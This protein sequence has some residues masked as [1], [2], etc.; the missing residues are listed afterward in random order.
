MNEEVELYLEDAKDK[1]EKAINHLENEMAKVR[2][3][4]ASPQM[5]DGIMVDNYGAHVPLSQV[6]NI[7]T[8]DPRTITVQPWDKNMLGIIEKAILVANLGITPMSNGEVIRINI[9]MLTE[10]RRRGLVK[11]VHSEGENA[12]IS[13]RS[14]RREALEE[15]KKLQKDGLPEDEANDAEE[16]I[17]KLTDSF[18]KKTDMV[19]DKK[20]KDIMTV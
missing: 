19:L 2:A 6:S 7:N 18:Y 10:E 4:K 12:K 3:G 5:L 15:I 13:I 20:E 1:M 16:N 11:Q 9:P 8:P 17:Q 14:A